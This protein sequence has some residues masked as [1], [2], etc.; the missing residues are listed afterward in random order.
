VLAQPEG[1]DES[2]VLEDVFAPVRWAYALYV[3]HWRVW[4]VSIPVAVLRVDQVIRSSQGIAGE[5]LVESLRVVQ[6]LL[7][8]AASKHVAVMALANG[9]AWKPRDAAS[10]SMRAVVLGLVGYAVVFGGLN[11]AV[12]GLVHQDAVLAAIPG[13]GSGH[14]DPLRARTAVTLAVKNLIVIPVS[15]ITLLR[16]VRLVP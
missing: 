8:I 12:Y 16:V 14:L 4:M 3:T 1:S 10:L 11:L 2:N 5:I 13:V 7:A 6:I 15:V 9:A